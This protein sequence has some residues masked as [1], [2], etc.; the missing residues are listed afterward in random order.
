MVVKRK[1]EQLHIRIKEDFKEDLRLVSEANGQTMSGYV[2]LLI[3]QA[4]RKAK[5]EMPEVFATKPALTETPER[6]IKH[7]TEA[8]KYE[9][10][11]KAS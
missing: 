8:K 11:R 4:I 6:I 1:Q 10:K 3:A 7:K 9:P 2:Y 5:T